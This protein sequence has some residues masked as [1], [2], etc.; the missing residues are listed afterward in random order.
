MMNSR[1]KKGQAIPL[2]VLALG[3]LLLGGLGLAIDGAQLYAQSQLA[4]VAA[5]AAATAGIMSMFQGVNVTGSATYFSTAAAFTCG[6]SDAKLPCQ[7]ARLNG[8]G[9]STNDTVTVDFP[10]CSVAV[11][12]GYETALSTADSPN[13]IRVTITR[14]VKNSFIRMLGG[15]LATPVKVTSV[16]AMVSVETPTPILITDPKNSNTLSMNGTTSIT[17][18]G[19]PSRSIE[20]NSS[21]A[22]AYQGGGTIDLTHAGAADPGNC[23]TGTGADFG[24]F[25]GAYKNPG[26]V[27]LGSTGHYLSKASPIDDPLASVAAPAVPITNGTK[28]HIGTGTHGCTASGGCTEYTP[29]LYTTATGGLTPGNDTVIFQPGLYYVQGGGVDFKQTVGGGANYNAMCVGCLA[30]PDTGNGMVIYDT[31]PA[32]STTGH[33]N[34]GG[35]NIGTKAYLALQGATNT[36][37]NPLGQVVP[38]APYYGILFWEDRTADTH[39]HTFGQ[40][41]GCFS[42]VGT[43]YITN[44][45]SIMLAD[46]THLQSVAYNG[47]PCSTTIQQGDIIVG[48]LSLVGNTAITMNLVPYG[49][50]TIRQVALVGG[51][52]R[53]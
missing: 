12:C 48:Q 20:V 17:I 13:Q 5:D 22:S 46:S 14:S 32:G 26:A 33:N 43:I 39:S 37:T 31:G 3:L 25:G 9:A 52:P 50:T 10:I 35:F 51:G 41:N 47:T 8:F 11:P 23:T 15:A 2:L 16:A 29:G 30:D 19:G 4:Q 24:V 1:S 40:G 38:A 45:K 44:Y 6:T 28:S 36:T 27:S 34:S 21:S 18:C 7:Y 53:P 42:L 49:F